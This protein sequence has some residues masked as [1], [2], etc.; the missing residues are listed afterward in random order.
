MSRI[1]EALERA[2]LTPRPE[3]ATSLP[4]DVDEAAAQPVD[5]FQLDDMQE[6]P[7]SPASDASDS[8]NDRTWKSTLR[9]DIMRLRRLLKDQGE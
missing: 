3:N 5:P 9:Q 7:P 8:P 2:S 6:A 1:A 4:G